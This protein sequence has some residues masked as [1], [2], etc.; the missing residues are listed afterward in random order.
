MLLRTPKS[1]S[2]RWQMTHHG[3]QLFKSA[4]PAHGELNSVQLYIF[5]S[6]QKTTTFVI[7]Q[8]I[9]RLKQ[10]KDNWL[11]EKC[12]IFLF[13]P[14]KNT[15]TPPQQVKGLKITELML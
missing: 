2:S 11:K 7:I 5:T 9:R 4:H 8:Y 10:L 12:C 14:F 1:C 3:S 13:C 15:K 6:S